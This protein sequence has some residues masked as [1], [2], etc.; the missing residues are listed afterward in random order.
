M[1]QL[2]S[3]KSKETVQEKTPRPDWISDS[4]WEL[5]SQR[6]NLF[7]TGRLTEEKRKNLKHRIRSGLRLD[8]KKRAKKAGS[9]IDEFLQAGTRT[10]INPPF[11]VTLL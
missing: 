11:F 2:L 7:K 10:T 6:V 1:G 9:Q 4:T 3:F 8:R 5:M